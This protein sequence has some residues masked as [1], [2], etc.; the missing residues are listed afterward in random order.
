[1]NEM[2]VVYPR[3]CGIDVHKKMVVACLITPENKD[4]DTKTFSTM[5]DELIEMK[6]WL[7]VHTWPWKVQPHTGSQFIIC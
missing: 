3:C 4:G 1:V 5:T 2:D 7:L 6:E